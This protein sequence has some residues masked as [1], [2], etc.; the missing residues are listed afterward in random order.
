MVAGLLDDH[1]GR[2]PHSC[3]YL[4]DGGE[5]QMLSHKHNSDQSDNYTSCD[6]PCDC[7]DNIIPHRGL[8]IASLVCMDADGNPAYQQT[9]RHEDILRRMEGPGHKVLCIPSCFK[10][11][12]PP[13]VVAGWPENLTIVLANRAQRGFSLP[14]AIRLANGPLHE[15]LGGEDYIEFWELPNCEGDPLASGHLSS[16]SPA[17]AAPSSNGRQHHSRH[18]T[19]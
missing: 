9:Q 8:R 12:Q 5:P 15:W 7:N 17:D 6:L 18:S 3:A 2:N 19:A 16:A 4:I 1:V 10:V 14:S 13:G 11:T